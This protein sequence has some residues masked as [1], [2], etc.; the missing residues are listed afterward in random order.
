[1][2]DDSSRPAGGEKDFRLGHLTTER[3]HP[4]TACLSRTAREDPQAALRQLFSVDEDIV[5]MLERWCAGELPE[6]LAA[7]MARV[8]SRGGRVFFTGCGATGRL[9]IFL[10][11]LSRE[12]WNTRPG[13]AKDFPGITGRTVSVMAGGDY[14]LVKSVE[15]YEDFVELGE[16][17]L[18]DAGVRSGDLVV[19]ITEG[20]ETSFVI[21]TALAG[22]DAGARVYFVYNNPR[23]DIEGIRRCREVLDHPGIEKMCLATGPMALTGSTRMQAATAELAALG[24][25]LENALGRLCG[26]NV[27]PAGSCPGQFSSL[28]AALT[29]RE[30]IEALAG[31][32]AL[33]RD[34]YSRKGL[35]TYIADGCALD[36][37]TDTTERS[38]TFMVP[39]FVK[40]GDSGSDP[41]WCYVV[42]PYADNDDAWRIMLRRNISAISWSREALCGMLGSGS[43]LASSLPALDREQVLRFDLSSRALAG[44]VRDERDAV[45]L[46]LAGEEVEYVCGNGLEY[47]DMLRLASQRTSRLGL[48]VLGTGRQCIEAS[49]WYRGR[50]LQLDYFPVTVPEFPGPLGLGNRLALKLCANAVST[51]TMTLMERVMGNLMVWVL[52]SNKKLYDR[53]SRYVS[54]ITREPYGQCLDAVSRVMRASRER[55]DHGCGSVAP[56]VVASL[57]LLRRLDPAGAEAAFLSAVEKGTGLGELLVEA[58]GEPGVCGR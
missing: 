57:M 3:P 41:S 49:R 5:G 43:A 24:W 31:L 40:G 32:A 2:R 18:R 46:F 28:L 4:R 11:A 53:A 47:E 48:F 44:R 16:R 15:G 12:F 58:G 30:N 22:A 37:L 50:G 52:P 19:A 20:G 25:C 51:L 42:T 8:L 39:P 17:Q 27:R 21:G 26:E 9:A 34:V 38:P 54:L 23:E 10:D 56:V 33:E 29:A 55:A 35:V 14:A 6:M 36:L 1:M 45:V 13:Q 7:D